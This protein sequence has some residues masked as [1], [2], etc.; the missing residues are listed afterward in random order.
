MRRRSRA[1]VHTLAAMVWGLALLNLW[2]ALFVHAHSRLLLLRQYLPL[3]VIHGSRLLTVVVGFLLLF[4]GH[5]LWRHKR[6]AWQFS[7]SALGISALLHL[8]K[9]LD[10]EEAVT[11]LLVLAALVALRRQYRAASD[12]PSL[13]RGLA[14]LALSI[15]FAC[16]YGTVGF[17]YLDRQFHASF[18]VLDSIRMTL[19]ILFAFAEP[20]MAHGGRARW[21]LGSLYTVGAFTLLYGAQAALKPVL[22]RSRAWEQER[23]R[24]EKIAVRH[25]R[26]S[27][28]RITLLPDKAF[29]FPPGLDA[30]ISF[31]VVGN[32]AVVLGDPIGPDEQVPDAIAA[33][34]DH[35]AEMDWTPCYFQVLPDYLPAYRAVGYQYIKIGEEAV[36]DL[37]SFD[38]QGGEWK[39][40]RHIVSKLSRLNWAV[41]F[42]SPPIEAPLIQQLR[43]VSEDWLR[44]MGG[45]EKRFS[46]GWFD[47]AYLSECDIAVVESPEGRIEAFANF[48]TQYRSPVITPDL[49]RRRRTAERGV[50]DLLIVKAAQH[51]KELGFQGLNLGLAPLAGV[52]TESDAGVPERVLHILYSHFNRLYSF[53]GVRVFK[54][55]YRPRWE[56]RYLIYTS[57][58][59]LPKAQIAVVRANNP[60]I[61]WLI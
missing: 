23:D 31:R 21:F 16:V 5:G 35:C 50:M 61:L 59:G 42:Y 7:V 25:G 19:G 1:G 10:W 26:S 28:V 39:D 6:R 47:P 9:G 11:S 48:V 49:M 34:D 53:T 12:P 8:A 52:G 14:V 44:A 54:A 30:Y 27:L 15:L 41:R 36:I 22:Y 40:L 33:F 46:L 43:Q 4:L 60:G 55:K 56:P 51:Y 45:K 2:S 3:E 20:P 57:A 32:V 29:Y 38:M 17:Y 58:A 13:R 18:D 37:N 24:A